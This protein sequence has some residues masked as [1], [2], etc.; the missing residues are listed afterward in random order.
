MVSSK[1]YRAPS[2][3]NKKGSTLGDVAQSGVNPVTGEYLSSQQRKA[4]FRKRTVSSEKVFGKPGAI[5]KLTPS[6]I[7]PVGS[8]ETS[9]KSNIVSYAKQ[10][11]ISPSVIDIA[12]LLKRIIILEKQVSTLSNL[13]SKES[14]EEN[15]QDKDRIKREEREE[16]KRRRS[17][18]SSGLG[19]KISNL[20]LSPV[21]SVAKKT[22]GILSTLVEFFTILFAGWLTDK[23]LSAIKLNSEGNIQ[24]LEDLKN[25]VLKNLAVVGGIFL[26]L[27]GGIFVVLGILKSLTK[28]ILKFAWRQT[29]GKLFRP[30]TPPAPTPPPAG[31][32]GAAAGAG[33]GAAA[34]AAGGAS[35]ATSGLSKG[36]QAAK[37][38]L[39]QE[40][41]DKG[42]KAKGAMIG[43]KYISVDATEA[44]KLLQKPNIF[45][46]MFQGVGNLTQ[47]AVD[48]IKGIGDSAK[49]K[50]LE[51][52]GNKIKPL[53][54]PMLNS[55]KS[56][57]GKVF[58]TLEKLPGF[59]QVSA[60]L[61]KQ[62][63]KGLGDAAGIA[64]KVGAKGIPVIGGLI[65]LAFAYDRLANG[66]TVGAGLEALSGLLDLSALVGFA[67]GPGISL[68][69]DAFLFARDFIPSIKQGEES[70]LK[71]LGLS[72]I[73]G[74]AN[75]IGSKLPNI[76]EIAKMVNGGKKPEQ[77]K[78]SETSGTGSENPEIER[79]SPTPIGSQ[80]PAAPSSALAP[81]P[82]ISPLSD[83]S[84]IPSQ[85]SAAPPQIIYRRIKSGQ[86]GQGAQLESGS[87]TE[88]PFISSSNPD[89]FYTLY[90]QVNYNV[91]M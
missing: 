38:K 58:G 88:V 87:A 26:A 15:K 17:S 80:S 35:A 1:I 76:G 9:E 57:S 47:G 2:I 13:I 30:P 85:S 33:G 48:K 20:L 67:P 21:E 91:V 41:V 29:F 90:S 3:L 74:M 60:F 46:R 55:I 22:Q 66:D 68:G 86:G 12:S 64:K 79:S 6:S 28:R 42:L 78:A 62:G 19:K 50:I 69:L 44:K 32:G 61:K 54:E 36:Q 89:N 11:G 14:E 59:K 16:E 77:P 81:M 31:G 4:L 45:Q 53:L 7:A 70:L 72:G 49:N 63:I 18:K 56:I 52:L 27:N 39:A 37:L 71:S 84:F 65:N 82:Q 51:F 75:K 23:G 73:M 40:V 83:S 25:T 8:P 10:Q 43:G 24:A 5:V 34:A